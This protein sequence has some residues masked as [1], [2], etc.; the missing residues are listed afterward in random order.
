MEEKK[1]ITMAK[2]GRSMR[3]RGGA[4]RH[5]DSGSGTEKGKGVGWQGGGMRLV[6]YIHETL[7]L[8]GRLSFQNSRAK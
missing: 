5:W 2:V 3:S 8:R 7:G 4:H 1:N 6:T